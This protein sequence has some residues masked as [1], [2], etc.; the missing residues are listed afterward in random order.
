MIRLEEYSKA[1]YTFFF[2]FLAFS[3]SSSFL[4]DD[5]VSGGYVKVFGDGDKLWESMP[6]AEFRIRSAI[7]WISAEQTVR[8]LQD[9][10]LDCAKERA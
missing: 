1:V 3:G 2:D 8:K 6:T 10:S 9:L 5:G 7:Y 4:F